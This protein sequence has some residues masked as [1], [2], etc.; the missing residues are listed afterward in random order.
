MAGNAACN[1]HRMNVE[2]TQT[3]PPPHTL[4]ERPNRHWPLWLRSLNK[5]VVQIQERFFRNQRVIGQPFYLTLESGNS[6]NLRCPL[7]PTTF[8]GNSLPRGT[9]TLEN[10]RTI[11]DRFPA[12]LAV[13]FSLWGEPFLNKEIFDIVRYARSKKIRACIQ[14]NFSLPKFDEA[15]A[16]RIL[17]SDL[18]EL[19]LSIDGASQETYEVYRRRGDFARV[20]RNIELLR[21]LQKD[22]GRRNP[23]ITW[24][25]VVNKFNEHEIATARAAADC[26]RLEFLVV[27]IYT[28]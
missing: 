18:S 14:S 27:E 24:K 1:A 8:R 23:K 6:C 2:S 22:Q 17:D 4:S 15:M 16:Q 13:N 25:M 21:R 5:R 10:A 3:I 7:C 9:L 19:S 20:L 12:L 28:P 11:L 26:V